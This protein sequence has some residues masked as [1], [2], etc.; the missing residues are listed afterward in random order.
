MLLALVYFTFCLPKNLFISPYA[1][2]V[3][4]E[5]GALL[6]ATIASDGQWRFPP[7]N[8][9]PPKFEAALI[10]FEDQHFYRHMGVSLIA[11]G[12]A[13]LQNLSAGHVVSG[14]STISMQVIRMSRHRV[15]RALSDK[16]VEMVQAIRLEVRY[17]KKEILG[18]HSAHAP[19]G[20]NVVGLEAASWRYFGHKPSQLSWAESA[21][22]AVLPNAP[23]LIH[24]GKNRSKL[25]AKRNRLLKRL[26]QNGQ[27]DEGEYNAALAEP[28]P[29]KPK[30]LPQLTP[31]YLTL[32][33]SKGKDDRRFQTSINRKLQRNVNQISNHHYNII[34]A[35]GIQN[36]GLVVLH[37]PSGE[38][39]AYVGNADKA[40]HA[41]FVDVVQAPRSTGSILKP[42]LYASAM[43]AGKITP[44]MLLPDYPTRIHGYTPHNYDKTYDGMVPASQALSRSL[45]IPAVRLLSEYGV[46]RFKSD[47]QKLGLTTLFRP[48]EEYGLSLIL[49][50]AEATL[51]DLA[52]AYR[53]LAISVSG[54]D[55]SNS[56]K[57][58]DPAVAYEILHAMTEVNRP[59][60]EKYWERFDGRNKI[61]WKTGTSFGA[62]DAWAIGISPDYVVAVWV[63]NANGEG[64]AGMTGSNSAGPILF[65]VFRMLP[66][67]QWFKQPV[68]H[69][70]FVSICIESGH[71]TGLH[72]QNTESQW[73]PNTCLSSAACVYHQSVFMNKAGTQLTYKGKE[74]VF[75]HNMFVLPAAAAYYYKMGHPEY[76]NLPANLANDGSTSTDLDILYPQV[77]SVIRV[78]KLMNGSYGD[79]V[80]ES[81][82]RSDDA[83][84]YWFIDNHFITSTKDIHQIHT[85]PEAGEHVLTVTDGV[86]RS[87][88]RKFSVAY[89]GPI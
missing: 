9:I 72:C 50:G 36:I 8:E 33:S 3:E 55:N 24:P 57:K 32:L 88:S 61:A 19:F 80:F 21:T 17:S 5:E 29:Q 25:L 63:G 18:L 15:G 69:M 28:L 22:L 41:A 7:G 78:P 89:S 52:Y 45:N 79:I 86:G 84:I 62:R 6:M 60:Q 23:A 76:K 42:F 30:A 58:Y 11:I 85:R 68:R 14:G 77:K 59:G 74:E 71:R 53:Q 31:H 37:V 82:H 75:Q 40:N 10:E 73:L 26:W 13:C 12:R 20:G 67:S 38:I 39:K 56:L 83:E 64:I 27:M 47:I 65:D 70:K 43:E 66:N 49:G 35:R 1:T 34:S 4:D 48:A 46:S 16:L 2:V 44:K 87:L 54:A 51:W 81:V